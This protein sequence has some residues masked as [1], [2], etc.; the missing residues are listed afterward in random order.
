[1]GIKRES[2]LLICAL[3][4]PLLGA[5]PSFS[6]PLV[7]QSGEELGDLEL[8]P[9]LSVVTLEDLKAKPNFAAPTPDFIAYIEDHRDPQAPTTVWRL[10]RVQDEHIPS[11]SKVDEQ[12][13]LDVCTL[14]TLR[15][16]AFVLQLDTLGV[17]L[18]SHCH[19]E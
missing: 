14:R 9:G 11:G 19:C 18:I 1:M 8:P 2:W 7:T 12:E 17:M 3:L 4:C 16:K 6:F 10:G 13:V 15:E 5:A